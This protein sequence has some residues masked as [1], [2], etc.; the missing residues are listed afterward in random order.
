LRAQS[1][2]A[3]I[4]EKQN[5]KKNPIIGVHSHSGL[6]CY[7]TVYSTARGFDNT[8]FAGL[9]ASLGFVSQTHLVSLLLYT[10]KIQAYIRITS[11]GTRPIRVW[12]SV[13]LS[14]FPLPQ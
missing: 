1:V 12:I 11:F 5:E 2:H 4:A 8:S 3:H 14:M 13:S 7:S 6:A 9:A 10:D